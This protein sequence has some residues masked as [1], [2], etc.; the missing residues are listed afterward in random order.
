MYSCFFIFLLPNFYVG[1]TWTFTIYGVNKGV[2]LTSTT[3]TDILLESASLE[4]TFAKS[5]N[6]VNATVHS[7]DNLK[8]GK[9]SVLFSLTYNPGTGDFKA[10]MQK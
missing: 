3:S 7:S 6:V 8:T 9:G 2:E 4:L 5:K 10:K 1:D